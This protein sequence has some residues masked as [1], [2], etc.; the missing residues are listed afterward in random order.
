[1]TIKAKTGPVIRV[2]S[3]LGVICPIIQM[4]SRKFTTRFKA[5]ST[6]IIVLFK[7]QALPLSGFNPKSLS[8]N[9]SWNCGPEV[10]VIF[11]PK[12]S[13]ELIFTSFRASSFS[14]IWLIKDW[15]SANFAGEINTSNPYIPSRPSYL[16]QTHPSPGFNRHNPALVPCSRNSP[17][18]VPTSTPRNSVILH[19]S[20]YSSFVMAEHNA[21]LSR[22]D[23]IPNVKAFK[24]LLARFH[25]H[26]V[27]LRNHIRQANNT[28]ALLINNQNRIFCT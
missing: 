9:G 8:L 15:L 2:E 24:N 25:G 16:R 28:W 19:P 1:M 7:D 20:P 18:K 22:G 27:N 6:G 10:P 21:Y 13:E 12:G 17:P 23:L 26:L 14:S 4:V 11:P 3:L 5:F